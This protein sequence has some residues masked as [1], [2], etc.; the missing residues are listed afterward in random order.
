M[1]KRLLAT[2]TVIGGVAMA[3]HYVMTLRYERGFIH[4][5]KLISLDGDDWDWEV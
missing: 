5:I 1:L 3:L 2:M 4:A